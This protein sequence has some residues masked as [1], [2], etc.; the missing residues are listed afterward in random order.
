MKAPMIII[1]ASVMCVGIAGVAWL[2]NSRPIQRPASFARTDGSPKDS[3]PERE[4]LIR[5]PKPESANDV[6][7]SYYLDL[8]RA[9]MEHTHESY[10]PYRLEPAAELMNELRLQHELADNTGS[11]S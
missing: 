6:R 8:L 9:A 2:Y 1:A 11:L 10:G 4:V 3:G 7:H 5:Y